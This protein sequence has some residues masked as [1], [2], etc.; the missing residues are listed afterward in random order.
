MGCKYAECTSWACKHSHCQCH[1][2][3]IS[4]PKKSITFQVVNKEREMER[5]MRLWIVLQFFSVSTFLRSALKFSK[6][7]V[8]PRHHPVICAHHKS[9]FSFFWTNC[10]CLGTFI[11]MFM[12]N[13]LLFPALSVVYVMLIG[14]IFTGSLL[15]SLTPLY[16][17]AQKSHVYGLLIK[18]DQ[19][20]LGKTVE[21]SPT[22]ILSSF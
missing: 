15:N 2:P 11:Q 14:M 12:Y 7:L 21:L 18:T 4:I 1:L 3:L 10:K 19:M 17:S 6:L 22:Y 8:Q 20:I 9:N 13:F 16:E 5:F